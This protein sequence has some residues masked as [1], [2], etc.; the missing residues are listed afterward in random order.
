MAARTPRTTRPDYSGVE[1]YEYAVLAGRLQH[2]RDDS[3][4]DLVPGA[5]YALGNRFGVTNDDLD[6]FVDG[7]LASR[8]GIEKAI[9]TYIR[10]YG[11]AEQAL[12]LRDYHEFV[13]GNADYL[14]NNDVVT[15]VLDEFGGENLSQLRERIAGLS[16]D[17]Q[18]PTN[19]ELKT[20]AT[21]ELERYDNVLNL[22]QIMQDARY[23]I[24]LPEAVHRTNRRRLQQ[25]EVVQRTNMIRLQ[26]PVHRKRVAA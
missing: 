7:T 24:M 15:R 9:G 23:A 3:Q 2:S 4:R 18:H 19:G 14:Q 17:S 1:R 5:L 12:S 11:E 10:K 6:G 8:Q 13:G 25:L 21:Q 20:S 22:L 26:Q 16:H